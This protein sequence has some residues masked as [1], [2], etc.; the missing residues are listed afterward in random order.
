MQKG[1]VADIQR[2][3]VHDGPGIRTTVFLKGCPLRCAWC[4]NPE[5]TS[6]KPQYMYYHEKCI[7]CGK[8][9]EGCF[10][11]A[12]V[13]CG[14][15]MTVEDVMKEVLLDR[16]YYAEEGGVTFSGGE[17]L[18]QKEFLSALI[19]ACR[20]KHI[21]CAVETSLIYY[22]E[23][24]F[25]KLDL[26]MAD[27][28]CWDDETHRKYTGVSNLHVK[29]NFRKL[30]QLGIPIIARTPVIPE[31]EQG[32]EEISCFLRKL[33]KVKKYELLPYHPLGQE[34]AEALQ[35]KQKKFTVPT[36]EYVNEMKQYEFSR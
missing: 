11:G 30:N 24:I 27:L 36:K 33:E 15:G 13:I 1:I 19:D 8:C 20:E 12:R 6:F 23:D 3:S 26:V 4:H 14:K 5:C 7:G 18:A 16:T 35:I 21:H 22:D 34:K 10:S 9:E 28:K 32:I 17:P 2:A 29:E 31:I 25:K